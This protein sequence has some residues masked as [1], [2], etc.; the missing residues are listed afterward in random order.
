MADPVQL[1]GFCDREPAG[2]V[3]AAGIAHGC[4][5]VLIV[6]HGIFLDSRSRLALDTGSGREAGGV[7][8]G[9]CGSGVRLVSRGFGCA[10]LQGRDAATWLGLKIWDRGHSRRLWRGAQDAKR[11]VGGLTA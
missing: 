5:V 8:K 11:L 1:V 4:H 2:R 3:S 9:R 6:C 7:D 10:P